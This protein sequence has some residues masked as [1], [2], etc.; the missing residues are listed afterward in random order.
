LLVDI[1]REKIL[2]SHGGS[3]ILDFSV[4]AD[5]HIAQRCSGFGRRA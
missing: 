1:G 5:V 2:L 4:A 3:P